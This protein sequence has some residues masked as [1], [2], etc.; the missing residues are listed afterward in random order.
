[1]CHSIDAE[2][3]VDKRIKLRNLGT[4]NVRYRIADLLDWFV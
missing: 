3:P 2:K 1:M 4:G